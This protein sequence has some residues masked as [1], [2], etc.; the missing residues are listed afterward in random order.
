MT[1][2]PKLVPSYASLFNAPFH[3][4]NMTNGQHRI[5]DD[6][7]KFLL[8]NEKHFACEVLTREMDYAVCSHAYACIG[9]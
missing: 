3:L 6:A 4:P 2:T 1:F 8:D 5:F 9:Q 7:L